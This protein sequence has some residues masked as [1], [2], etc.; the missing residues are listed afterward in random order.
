MRQLSGLQL[1]Y[2]PYAQ[3]HV[4]YPAYPLSA[5]A[6]K[7]YEPPPLGATIDEYRVQQQKQHHDDLLHQ[8]EDNRRRKLLEQQLE[9]QEEER[10]R[11][12]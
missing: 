9:A 10:E 7:R 3:K 4:D 2:R 1:A 5:Y 12:R 8:I 6:P 11:W